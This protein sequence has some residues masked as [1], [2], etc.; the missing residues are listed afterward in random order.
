MRRIPKNKS[1]AETLK[2][3]DAM[4]RRLGESYN[5]LVVVLKKTMMFDR[6]T[7]Q[8]RIDVLHALNAHKKAIEDL[9]GDGDWLKKLLAD[10]P[11]P[12]ADKLS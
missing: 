8:K 5:E 9:C 11:M 6:I 12:D 2:E 10:L 3:G 4:L 7:E 1:V